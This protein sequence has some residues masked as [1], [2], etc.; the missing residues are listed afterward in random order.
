VV[1]VATALQESSA[2]PS[3]WKPVRL[4]Q[5]SSLITSGSRGWAAHYADAGALF[6]RSQNVRDGRLDFSDRQYVVP[7]PGA[8]GTRTRLAPGDVLITITGNSVGNVAWVD[9]DLG[10]AYISQHVGLVRLAT[11]VLAPF[12]CRYLAPGA[13]GNPQIA[14]SQS[15]QSKP[16]LNLKNLEDFLIALPHPAEAS[17]I[18][19]AL[20]DVD[21]LL[22]ALDRL[23]A[24]KRDLKQAAMQQLLTGQTRLPGFSGKWEETTL[25]ALGSWFSGGTPSKG[26]ENYWTGEI[27]WVSPKDMKVARILDAIDH[28]GQTAIGN[29]TRL[30]P[31]GAILIVVRGMILAHSAPVARVER[32]VAFNQDIKGLVVRSDIDSNFVLWWLIAHEVLLLSLTNEATHGTKRIPTDELLKLK[33]RVPGLNEQAAVAGAVTDMDAELT[34]L[35]QRRDKTRLL[36]QGMMQ[37]LLTGRTR[38]V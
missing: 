7:P 34:A 3:D 12:V 2:S 16:G 5:I 37:E 1:A 27:P 32:P 26:N 15:G 11:P 18:A 17:A 21:A 35:E 23:I 24:K 14:A 19:A 30:L 29:G 6:V 13:P 22:G 4:G 25:G 33:L 9:Q 10:D 31:V 28:V 8:E 20:S 38:L 36:K